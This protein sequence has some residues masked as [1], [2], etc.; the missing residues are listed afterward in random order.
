MDQR[1]SQS[2][3][4][5]ARYDFLPLGP[6]D[7]RSRRLNGISNGLFRDTLLD[8]IKGAQ[9]YPPTL[10][11]TPNT[12]QLDLVRAKRCLKLFAGVFKGE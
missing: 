10:T 1:D 6:I 4:E 3:S 2:E 8:H 12:T 7:L 9:I 5:R 11:M